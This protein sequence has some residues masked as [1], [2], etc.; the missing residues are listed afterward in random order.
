LAIITIEF[1]TKYYLCNRTAIFFSVVREITPISN[2]DK[3]NDWYN[4][5]NKMHGVNY[6]W[7]HT[8]F[9]GVH[10]AKCLVFCVVLCRSLFVLFSLDDC[11]VLY[12]LVLSIFDHCI[13][14]YILLRFTASKY[15]FCNK[16]FLHW[17][18]SWSWSFGSWICNYLYSIST[19]H[20]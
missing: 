19:Y 9:D 15:T 1:R 13:V 4:K 5:I 16:P 7:V 18:P 14:L 11:I 17:G 8:W 20:H 12:I 10:V 6:N 3:I 2:G